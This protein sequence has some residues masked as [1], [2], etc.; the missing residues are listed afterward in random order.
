MISITIS[1]ILQF[2]ALVI[3]F[4]TFLYTFSFYQLVFLSFLEIDLW[5]KLFDSELELKLDRDRQPDF[6][7]KPKIVLKS[8]SSSVGWLKRPGQLDLLRRGLLYILSIKPS[9]MFDRNGGKN[10]HTKSYDAEQLGDWMG[11]KAEIY[12]I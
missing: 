6:D 12:F 4:I 8:T 7:L 9:S 2:C 3:S 10:R 5:P 1:K 11:R